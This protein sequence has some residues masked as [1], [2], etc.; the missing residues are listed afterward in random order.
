LDHAGFNVTGRE[1]MES[2]VAWLDALGVEHS[3]IRT[4]D[5]P[6]PYAT[7]VFRDPDNIQLEL[8]AIL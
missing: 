5:V 2:W 8:F 4:G 6:F 7:L 1:E 3:G